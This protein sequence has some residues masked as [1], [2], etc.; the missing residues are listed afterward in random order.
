MACSWPQ[1][2][3]PSVL[4]PLPAPEQALT[5]GRR[6]HVAAARD[7]W[8]LCCAKHCARSVLM[9]TATEEVS[10]GVLYLARYCSLKETQ[11][12]G[13]G[14]VHVL[15]WTGAFVLAGG[16]GRQGRRVPGGGGARTGTCS[17]LTPRAAF[18]RSPPLCRRHVLA[19]SQAGASCYAR[20]GQLE[21][22]AAAPRL[23]FRRRVAAPPSVTNELRC[24]VVRVRFERY[25]RARLV[26]RTHSVRRGGP[27]E[28]GSYASLLLTGP[29]RLL[30]CCKC[31]SARGAHLHRTLCRQAQSAARRQWCSTALAPLH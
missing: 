24:R 6:D 5:G 22:R 20:F 13:A 18:C 30:R 26:A 16:G 17:P 31:R 7:F 21:R 9:A 15:L 8:R 27:T 29:L 28:P 2:L 4:P 25:E 14:H 12:R 3:A 10:Q 19:A 11:P 1:T 23:V